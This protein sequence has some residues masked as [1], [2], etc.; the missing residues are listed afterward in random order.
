M[1]WPRSTAS[2]PTKLI[3][4]RGADD[5]IDMLVRTFCRAGVDAISICPPTFSAYAHFARL[6]G[7]RVVEA[8]LDADFD[9]DADALHRQAEGRGRISSSPSSA[10][11]TIRPATSSPPADILRIA[12]A[13]PE[14]I[15][16][17]DEAYIEFADA[18]EP[19]RREPT[20]RPN[21]VVLRTLSK[22]YRPRRGAGRLRDRQCRADRSG[23]ARLAA[24]PAAEPVHRGR[25]KRALSPSR[26][27]IHEE[28]IAQDQGGPRPASPTGLRRAPGVSNVRTGGGN[29]LFLEVAEPEALAA[30]LRRARHPRP[31]PAQCRARRGPASASAPRPKMP[32]CSPRFGVAGKAADRRRAEMVRDTKETQIAVAVDLDSA[33]PRR[34]DTGVPF[35]DHMLDQVAAHGSFSLTARLQGRPRNRRASQPRGLRDRLRPGLVEGARPTGAA[36]AASASRCRWT[37]PRRMC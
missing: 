33:A 12:D 11:P 36:S 14:T 13:L 17:L 26:R 34:I 27:P 25:G 5:A 4:T 31:L 30:K 7:A 23:R 29:F 15:I 2:A 20:R 16:V 10:R 22:A 9:L 8:P 19:R 35:F 21:L 37:R 1:P 32:R 6:Q 24:L 18:R 3:V 28:R